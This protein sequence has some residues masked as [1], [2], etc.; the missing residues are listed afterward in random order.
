MKPTKILPTVLLGV[1][2]LLVPGLARAGAITYSTDFLLSSTYSLGMVGAFSVQLD[3][4]R[5]IELPRYSG[6]D[7]LTGVAINVTSASYRR[8]GISSSDDW[9][10]E[11]LVSILPPVWEFYGNEAS[12]EGTIDGEL[13]F[14]LLNPANVSRTVHFPKLSAACGEKTLDEE[15]AEHMLCAAENEMTNPYKADIP[16]AGV[17]LADFTGVDPI[18]FLA[19]INGLFS[20][21]CGGPD[22]GNFGV[23]YDDC[24]SNLTFWIWE[25][26]VSVTY[27]YGEAGT[28]TGGGGPTG[29]SETTG[30][31]S[32]SD[33]PEPAGL[34]AVGVALTGVRRLLR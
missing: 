21:L 5:L 26:S 6:P 28:T 24:S 13:T 10:N 2:A 8:I 11:E 14:S 30:D 18:R 23:D 3:D 31:E 9:P 27:T 29:G 32:S 33:V 34:L 20:G 4:F 7:P 17:P 19:V 12:V 15:T 25:G 16:V 22:P 1:C